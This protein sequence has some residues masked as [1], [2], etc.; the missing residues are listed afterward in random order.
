VIQGM[1]KNIEKFLLLV[2]GLNTLAWYF[3]NM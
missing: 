1:F 2:R 3:D